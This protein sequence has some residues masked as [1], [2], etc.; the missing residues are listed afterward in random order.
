MRKSAILL[1]TIWFTLS[2]CAQEPVFQTEKFTQTDSKKDYL[3]TIHTSFGDMKA[4]L[5][6]ETPL[7]RDNFLD[8]AQN[9]HYDSTIWH[10]VIDE[11]MIQGGGIDMKKGGLR[12]SETIP[13]EFDKRLFHVKGALAAARTNNPAKASSWCQFYIVQG[14]TYTE[15]ELMIDQQKLNQGMRQLLQTGKHQALQEEIMELQEKRDFDAINKLIMEKTSLIETELGISV[16]KEIPKE[17]VA[18]YTSLGGAPHLDDAYTVFGQVVEGHEII[19]KIAAVKTKSGDR[20][21]ENLYLSIEV[22]QLSKKKIAKL[23][24]VIYPKK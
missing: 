3:V 20:P 13:A 10:R 23:Y 24:G 17:R 1:I 9:G 4:I 18:A 7:H 14:K 21:L 6:D 12:K 22:E 15:D 16:R 19:D 2:A 11:F 8:L 5:Y